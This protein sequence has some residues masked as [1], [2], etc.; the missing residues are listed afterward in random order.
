VLGQTGAQSRGRRTHQP[1]RQRNRRSA[2]SD[3]IAL[4]ELGSAKAT[5]P[6]IGFLHSENI[7]LVR[8]A[9]EALGRL[10]DERGIENLIECLDSPS[11]DV[12]K[13]SADA[14]V[15]IGE[16]AVPALNRP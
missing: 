10:G 5:V 7:D 9:A 11:I 15:K 16:A 6:L 2:K 12:R 4:G 14:L 3:D 13:A 1:P 8:F